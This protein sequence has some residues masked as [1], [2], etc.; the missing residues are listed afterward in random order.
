MVSCQF[1]T[2]LLFARMN[3][4]PAGVFFIARPPS[5]DL[6]R[7]FHPHH[8]RARGAEGTPR[9]NLFVADREVSAGCPRA[10]A[11]ALREK[12]RICKCT[13]C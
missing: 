13:F 1:C 11:A 4:T 5:R 2:S 9:K 8:H 3:P 12:R 6:G 10:T 7:S